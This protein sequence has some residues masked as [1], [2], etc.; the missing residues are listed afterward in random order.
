MSDRALNAYRSAPY[1]KAENDEGGFAGDVYN[2][3]KSWTCKFLFK[4]RNLRYVYFIKIIDITPYV[5]CPK[6]QFYHGVV[7]NLA[8]NM[9]FVLATNNCEHFAKWARND[10]HTSDQ[11]RMEGSGQV[12]MER[13]H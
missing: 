13:L 7:I 4:G 3:G 5:F 9:T 8:R 2:L 1:S 6:I 10:T 11:V 12:R